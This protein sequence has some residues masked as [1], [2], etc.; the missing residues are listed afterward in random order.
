MTAPGSAA[1]R[2][3]HSF[4]SADLRFISPLTTPEQAGVAH[5]V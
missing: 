2:M 4:G 5:V 1:R 3:A